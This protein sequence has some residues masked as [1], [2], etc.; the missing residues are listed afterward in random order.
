MMK[1]ELFTLHIQL[2]Y[3]YDDSPVV[4]SEGSPPPDDPP[5]TYTQTARPGSRAP[6][7]WTAPGWSTLD[8][9]GRGFVLLRFDPALDV[10]AVRSAAQRVALPLQVIDVDDPRIAALYERALVLVRP[11]G[12]VA[13]RAAAVT[14]DMAAGVDA[15]RGTSKR[16]SAVAK[17]PDAPVRS[18]AGR[19]GCVRAND[20]PDRGKGDA[21]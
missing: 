21:S 3:R 11:D 20:E 5:M 1:R 9:F 19:H 17:P 4:V 16:D 7:A 14:G 6:H 12:F 8:L 15:V 13:W 18:A 10:S 2:G